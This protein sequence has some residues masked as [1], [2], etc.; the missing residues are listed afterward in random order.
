M[1]MPLGIANY[2]TTERLL[3]FAL[4]VLDNAK[5]EQNDE[6]M[7]IINNRL[8]V[9]SYLKFIRATTASNKTNAII[10]V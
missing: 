2:H 7:P 9:V 4:A 1:S 5:C 6:R 10:S 8:R 3:E